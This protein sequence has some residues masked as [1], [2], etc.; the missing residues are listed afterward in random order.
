MERARPQQAFAEAAHAVRGTREVLLEG[1]GW[2]ACTVYDRYV[3]AAGAAFSGPALVEEREST[4]VIGPDAAVRVDHA[5]NLV[6][7]LP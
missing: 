6:I 5:L 2:R 3:L 7:E 1:A 4:C